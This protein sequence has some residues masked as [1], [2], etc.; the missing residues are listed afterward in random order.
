MFLF[1]RH[2]DKNSAA[3]NSRYLDFVQ[4]RG[5]ILLMN[6][7]HVEHNLRENS[8]YVYYVKNVNNLRG[9]S[10]ALIDV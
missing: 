2:S 8:V 6:D 10:I 3:V 1:T 7:N 9:E 5:L 4:T